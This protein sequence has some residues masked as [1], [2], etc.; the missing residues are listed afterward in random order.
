MSGKG[1]KVSADLKN[2]KQTYGKRFL[3][4]KIRCTVLQ[5]CIVFSLQKCFS[6]L[7]HHFFGAIPSNLM[8][9]KVQI[10]ILFCLVDCLVDVLTVLNLEGNIN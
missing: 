10:L 6:L 7:S 3:T 9:A 8:Y 2:K 5:I 1:E 4:N